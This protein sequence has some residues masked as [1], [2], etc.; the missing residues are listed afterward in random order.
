M[1]AAAVVEREAILASLRA[2]PAAGRAASD[3]ELLADARRGR[4]SAD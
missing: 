4:R 1:A 2:L 3:A